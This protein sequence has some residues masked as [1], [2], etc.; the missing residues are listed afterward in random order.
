MS[1][2]LNS[3]GAAFALSGAGPI[4]DTSLTIGAGSNQVLVA[5]VAQNS[6]GAPSATWD[7][8]ALTP[9]GT[10]TNSSVRIDILALKAPAQGNKTFSISSGTSFAFANGFTACFDGVD[11][12]T[13]AI[14]FASAAAGTVNVTSA[15]GNIVV[16]VGVSSSSLSAMNNTEFFHNNGNGTG[17]NW[18][19][20]AATVAVTSTNTGGNLATAGCDLLAAGAG[21]SS[22]GPLYMHRTQQRMN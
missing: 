11:Q 2:T 9:V 10:R 21:G 4:T 13:P 15:T 3:Q 1:G 16:G 17:A 12:S 8:V 5:F 19:V 22:A 18:A 14:N 20:G 6:T 7:G